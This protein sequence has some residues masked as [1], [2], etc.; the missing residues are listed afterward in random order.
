MPLQTQDDDIFRTT[1]DIRGWDIKTKQI[2]QA[3]TP[4]HNQSTGT[5]ATSKTKVE[6]VKHPSINVPTFALGTSRNHAAYK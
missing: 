1:H 4:L 2:W 5:V 3:E 6:K